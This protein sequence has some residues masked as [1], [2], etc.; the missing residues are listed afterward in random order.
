VHDEGKVAK[1]LPKFLLI[2]V[3]RHFGRERCGTKFV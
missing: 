2:R 1:Q 3:V